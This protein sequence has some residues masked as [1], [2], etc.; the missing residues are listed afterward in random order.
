[1]AALFEADAP[2]PG[3]VGEGD[4]GEGLSVSADERGGGDGDVG[5]GRR[6]NAAH[7]SEVP[8]R[9]LVRRTSDQVSP[10][11]ETVLVCA[12]AAAGPSMRTK[13]KTQRPAPVVL[14]VAVVW[15]PEPAAVHRDIHGRRRAARG[16]DGVAD[17]GRRRGGEVGVAGVDAG[18]GVGAEAECGGGEGGLAGDEGDGCAEVGDAVLELHRPGGDSSSGCGDRHGGGEAHRLADR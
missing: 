18:D 6:A 14:K 3:R 16:I 13:A 12:R 4:D 15:A 8:K 17:A 1:M 10:A 11:P 5:E 9:A 2:G 7:T